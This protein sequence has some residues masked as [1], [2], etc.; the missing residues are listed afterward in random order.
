MNK[1]IIGVL[2]G[3]NLGILGQREIEIY[4][5]KTLVDLEQ[6]L[7]KAAEKLDVEVECY[8]SNIEGK[9]IDKIESWR[10]K[11]S[12]VVFNPGAYAHTSIALRDAVSGSG[13]GF[14]EVHISNIHARETFRQHSYIASVSI[15]VIS[16]LGFDG[17]EAGLKYLAKQ[18]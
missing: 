10:R 6:Q 5:T 17:Y 4:G 8:Q 11:V 18:S 9:L 16:G 13:L 7:Q 1:K 3:P 14:I 15:C 12:G 2:N